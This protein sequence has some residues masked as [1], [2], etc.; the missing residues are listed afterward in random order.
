MRCSRE[1]FWFLCLLSF[2][3][4]TARA[5]DLKSVLTTN[6][7]RAG[8][9]LTLTPGGTIHRLHIFFYSDVGCSTILG[10]ADVLDLGEGFTF[11]GGQT[12][13]LNPSSAFALASNKGIATG[14]IACMKLYADGAGDGAKGAS[15]QSFTD[16][17]CSGSTCT[18]AQTKTV[19]WEVSPTPCA[20]R[21]GYFSGRDADTG[22]SFV[23]FCSLDGA[24][25]ALSDCADTGTGMINVSRMAINNGFAYVTLNGGV[26]RKCSV[27]PSTG[28]FSACADT[29]SSMDSPNGIA[30]NKGL[31]YVANTGGSVT[32]CDVSPATGLLSNC[33]STGSSM[34]EPI[35][36]SLH[37]GFAYITNFFDEVVKCTIHATTGAFSVC[38]ASGPD[39]S[40]MVDLTTHNGLLHMAGANS[41]TACSISPEDGTIS[42]CAATLS[43]NGPETLAISGGFLYVGFSSGTAEALKKCTVNAA[44]GALSGCSDFNVGISQAFGTVLY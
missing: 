3:S 7:S 17:A 2:N 6:V 41:V 44:T 8:P 22:D 37:N 4:L 30:L 35:T 19:G 27:D 9:A 25:G 14:S 32:K 23:R 38:A 33:A 12:V 16:L 29:G 43:V 15:C 26:V 20:D 24:T 13:H 21:F 10:R 28:A 31:A 18:S 40:A 1:G 11:S 39:T 36:L 42:D 5:L 34:P